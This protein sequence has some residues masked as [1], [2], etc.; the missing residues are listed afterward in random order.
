MSLSRTIVNFLNNNRDMVPYYLA[1]GLGTSIG[2]IGCVV[3]NN[4]INNQV[5]KRC[6]RDL[7]QVVHIKTAVGTSYGCVSRMVLQ[8]PPAPLK[9]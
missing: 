7:Y 3:L 6:N 8:G 1:M 5:I 2:L 4:A 9:P